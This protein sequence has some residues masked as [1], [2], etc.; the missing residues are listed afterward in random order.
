MTICVTYALPRPQ[1]IDLCNNP[2]TKEP[3]LNQATR[4]IGDRWTRLDK[5]RASIEAEESASTDVP[6]KARDEL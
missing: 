6:S 2:L 3:K 5:R 4:I 1:T